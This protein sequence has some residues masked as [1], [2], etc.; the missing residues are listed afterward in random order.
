MKSLKLPLDDKNMAELMSYYH[1]PTSLELFYRIQNKDIDLKD[2]KNFQIKG[3]RIIAPKRQDK[4]KGTINPNLITANADLLIFDEMSDKIAYSLAKCCNPIVGDDV[5]GF[6]TV[7]EGI[8]IHRTNCPNAT[9]LL[10]K[11]GYRAVKTRWTKQQ[12]IAFLTGLKITGVDDVGLV[13]KVTNVIS[14]EMKLN[15][16]SMTIGAKEGIFE[17]TFMVYVKNTDELEDLIHRISSLKE[18]TSVTRIE[19]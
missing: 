1:Q 14:G 16:Q 6:I 17:G 3:G 18:I 9:E 5:F 4:G 10:S 11:Y 8:K 7:N 19:T 15:M 13:N 12:E 2:L